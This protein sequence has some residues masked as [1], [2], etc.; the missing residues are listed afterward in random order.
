MPVLIV[1]SVTA[2]AMLIGCAIVAVLAVV[3]IARVVRRMLKERNV[4]DSE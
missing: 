4:R 1:L 3:S 2:N